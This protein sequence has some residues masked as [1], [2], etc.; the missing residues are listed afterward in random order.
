MERS[1]LGT[2]PQPRLREVFASINLVTPGLL[3]VGAYGA[4]LEWRPAAYLLLA[5]VTVLV[6]AN[7]AVGVLAYRSA[8]NRPWPPIRPLRDE[9]D[10]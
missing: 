3:V 8:M 2:T 4:L 5:A 10:W 1:Q 6:F 7:L 9:D